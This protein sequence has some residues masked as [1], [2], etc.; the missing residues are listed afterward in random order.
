MVELSTKP[1]LI[2][3]IYEWCAD[4]GY[5]PYLSVRVDENTRVP[6]EY[7]KE[8]EIV[9]NVG[10]GASRNLTIS[11]DIIQFSA[12]FNGVS[13]E[14]AVPTYAVQGIFARETGKGAFF[15]VE[16]TPE[17]FSVSDDKPRRAESDPKADGKPGLRLASVSTLFNTGADDDGAPLA[18][19]VPHI[20]ADKAGDNTSIRTMRS[21]PNAPSR[22]EPEPKATEKP[23]PAKPKPLTKASANKTTDLHGAPIVAAVPPSAPVANAVTP[24]PATASSATDTPPEDPPP[25]APSGSENGGKKSGLRVIK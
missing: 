21:V 15:E 18:D 23:M 12:R 25:T 22:S 4:C 14:I 11:N 8:G 16:E 24:L 10:Q 9:L 2:R 7:V 6:M 3:A 5:T 1:Y 13:R 19:S 20:A 17:N